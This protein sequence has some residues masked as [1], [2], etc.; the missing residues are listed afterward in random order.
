MILRRLAWSLALLA[1]SAGAQ[2]FDPATRL[3]T[4]PSGTSA[5]S[6]YA[7]VV[8]RVRAEIIGSQ[9]L[10]FY[11]QSATVTT[12]YLMVRP[13]RN[14]RPLGPGIRQKLDYTPLNAEDK[15]EQALRSHVERVAEAMRE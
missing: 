15:V 9:D 11:G 14:G 12:A 7:D 13:Y 6:T 1:V 10:Q 5:G 2:T 8:V 4:L 3:L